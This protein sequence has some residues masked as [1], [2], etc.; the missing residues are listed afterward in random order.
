MAAERIP[1]VS[2]GAFTPWTMSMAMSVMPPQLKPLGSRNN[3]N[4]RAN[5]ALPPTIISRFRA[6]TFFV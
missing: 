2:Q 3:T 5:R 6:K 1:T 4:P